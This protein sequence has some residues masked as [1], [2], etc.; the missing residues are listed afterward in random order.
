MARRR[1]STRRKRPGLNAKG[2]EMFKLTKLWFSMGGAIQ[3]MAAAAAVANS[4]RALDLQDKAKQK[5]TR[6]RGPIENPNEVT[7]RGTYRKSTVA[8]PAPAPPRYYQPWSL[9]IIDTAKS[10]S[11]SKVIRNNLTGK[12]TKIKFPKYIVGTVRGSKDVSKPRVNGHTVPYYLEHGEGSQSR[13]V[14]SV[15]AIPRDQDG[16]DQWRRWD[17]ATYRDEYTNNPR[18]IKTPRFQKEIWWQALHR[19]GQVPDEPALGG[20]E[21]THDVVWRKV[22]VMPSASRS[23]LQS[24]WESIKKKNRKYM[25]MGIQKFPRFARLFIKVSKEGTYKV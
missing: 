6:R 2:K 18:A 24:S 25:K 9:N 21:P 19:F 4:Y 12:T 3:A 1:K 14:R 16:V 23:W 5:I 10:M 11:D 17:G 22:R 8:L 13:Y 20:F 15:P 7:R